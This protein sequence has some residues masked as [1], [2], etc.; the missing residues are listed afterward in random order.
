MDSP[1]VEASAKEKFDVLFG[2]LRDNFNE[3]VDNSFRHAT[4]EALILGWLITSENARNFLQ[5]N[6]VVS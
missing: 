1:V 3:I 2:L 5:D 4:V 6:R